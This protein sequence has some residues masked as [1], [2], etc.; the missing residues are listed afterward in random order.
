MQIR[1]VLTGGPSAGKTTLLDLLNKQYGHLVAVA[2]EAASILFR[3]GFPRPV[4]L[5]DRVHTQRSI[6]ALQKELELQS[7]ERQA[8]SAVDRSFPNEHGNGAPLFCDRGA[9]D[10][11]A[12]WNGTVKEFCFAMG[13]SIEREHSRYTAVLHLQTA[14]EGMGYTN[15]DVRT[16]TPAEAQELD[17]RIGEVWSRHPN[18]IFIGNNGTFIDKLNSALTAL[19]PYLPD[20]EAI[21]PRRRYATIGDLI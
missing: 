5:D 3:G 14:A 15:T 18:Y 17:R 20:A 6:Y 8:Q 10:G 19:K 7:I 21:E 2:P 9:L 12:Y 16:E 11:A 13:T 4:T 1:I